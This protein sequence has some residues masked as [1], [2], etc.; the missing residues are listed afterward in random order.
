MSDE[1]QKSYN[2]RLK[3][4]IFLAIELSRG[5]LSYADVMVMPVHRLDE[6]LDW[7]IKFDKDREKAKAD[8]L[9]SLKM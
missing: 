1:Y 9:H 4:N 8:G 5:G 7:K 3:E 6:Y 2:R